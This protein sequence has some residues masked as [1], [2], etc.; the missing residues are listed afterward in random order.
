MKQREVAEQLD[1]SPSKVIR[2]EA[3]S[4]GVSVTDVRV[5]LTHY[6][7]TDPEQVAALTEMARAAR[8]PPWWASFRS[9]VSPDF[10]MYLGYESSASIIRNFESNLVPGLLQTEEYAREV[11]QRL[12]TGDERMEQL[13]QL[14]LERQDR[15]IQ[16]DGPEIFFIL[17]EAAVRRIVGSEGTMKKQYEKLLTVHEMPNVTVLTVPFS[18]G[19]YPQFR[20][21]YVLFEFLGDEDDMVAYLENADGEAILSEKALGRTSPRRP[22]DYLDDFWKVE[23]GVATEVTRDFLFGE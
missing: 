17:D 15:L 10:E 22:T 13:V 1:W 8:R 12:G 2:I 5:L 19:I 6:G 18:A 9:W 4:V 20:S 3:G 23:K 21:P 16:P 7:I 14:R 11:L